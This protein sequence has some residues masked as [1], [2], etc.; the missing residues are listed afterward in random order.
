LDAILLAQK[1]R[2][3]LIGDCAEAS[4]R[5]AETDVVVLLLLLRFTQLLEADS[6]LANE[7]LTVSVSAHP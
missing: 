5:I 2:D 3:L 4:Q 1:V 6:L 7:E